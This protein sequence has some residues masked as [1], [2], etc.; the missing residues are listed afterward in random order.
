VR[1][2]RQLLRLTQARRR[3]LCLCRALLTV[4]SCIKFRLDSQAYKSP[5]VVKGPFFP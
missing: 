2:R 5:I 3:L 1:A 4:N